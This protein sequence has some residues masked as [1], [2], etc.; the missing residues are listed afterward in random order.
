MDTIDYLLVGG[1]LQNALIASALVHRRPRVRVVVVEASSRVGGNHLWCFHALD[2]PE[3]AVAFVEP[4]VVRR[5]P[6]YRVRFPAYT[7]TL[8]DA[9][10]AVTSDAV[11]AH[12]SNLAATGRVELMLGSAARHIEPG[13][14]EL[15]SG[16]E[17]RARVVIDARGPERFAKHEAIGYQ[18][19][20]GL[21][22]E[23]APESVPIEPT[24]MDCTIDQVDGLRFFYVL[25]LAPNRVLVEDTYFPTIQGSTSPRSRPKSWP[26]PSEAGSSCAGSC[27]GNAVCFR[28][29]VALRSPSR[30]AQGSFG[31]VTRAAGFTRP[32]A[33]PSR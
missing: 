22:L 7:R 13:R 32:R 28:Y 20:V 27:A 9:Y 21:E 23:V 17:L 5:W 14:V 8:D 33:I 18:K 12:L 15:S 3:A 11:H 31:L 1:G 4:F 6:Q 26:M 30:K 24:L 2:V 29:R 25:P 16:E 10:A 19:F